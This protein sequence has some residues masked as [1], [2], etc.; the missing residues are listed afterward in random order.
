MN[1]NPIPEKKL[2]IV[3]PCP[4]P[5]EDVPRPHRRTREFDPHNPPRPR[6]N[7]DPRPPLPCFNNIGCM[8]C[9]PGPLLKK[10]MMPNLKMRQLADCYACR[11]SPECHNRRKNYYQRWKTYLDKLPPLPNTDYTVYCCD[12]YLDLGENHDF[13]RY[14]RNLDLRR[15]TSLLQITE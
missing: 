14:D 9:K 1:V 11:V 13:F 7:P 8:A 15:R 4:Y 10:P 2:L 5:G 3:P 12:D 6:V